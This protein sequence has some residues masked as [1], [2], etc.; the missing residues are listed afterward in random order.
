M[1]KEKVL[2]L[3]DYGFCK[4]LNGPKEKVYYN[5]GTTLYMS[6]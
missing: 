3:A 2:K 5:V 6:P 4:L 1:I